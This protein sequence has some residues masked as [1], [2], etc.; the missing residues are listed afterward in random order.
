V[1]KTI[2]KV[3]ALVI[4]GVVEGIFVKELLDLSPASLAKYILEAGLLM[5]GIIGVAYLVIRVFSLLTKD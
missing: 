2:E 3:I 1:G 5:G 4:G